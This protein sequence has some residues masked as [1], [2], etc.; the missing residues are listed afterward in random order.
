MPPSAA[1]QHSPAVR[2]AF[3]GFLFLYKFF[4]TPQKHN[5]HMRHRRLFAEK[6]EF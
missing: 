5:T 6:A 3:L 4:G 2:N 1:L